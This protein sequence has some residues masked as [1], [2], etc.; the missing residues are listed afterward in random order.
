MKKQRI[1]KEAQIIASQYPFWMVSGDIA[2]LYG[3][4]L[5]TPEENYELEIKFGGDFPAS[6]PHLTYHDKIKD[7]LGDIQLK[8]LKDWDETSRTIDILNELKSKLQSAL[9][10]TSNLEQQNIDDA[11]QSTESSQTPSHDD[12]EYITPDLNAFPPESQ[13]NESN[14]LSSSGDELFYMPEDS[15]KESY[16]EIESEALASEN[17]VIS[18]DE[19]FASSDSPSVQIMT[20]LGLIQQ[21]Y[22]YDQKSESK[23]D[24]IVYMTITLTKTFLIHIDFSKYPQR[25]SIS[26]PDNV[27]RL[28]PDPYETLQ[29]LK[30]WKKKRPPHVID[31][32]HELEKKLYSI[33]PIEEQLQ[34]IAQE[35]QYTPQSD[36]LTKIQVSLLTYGFKQYKVELDLEP[37]P[38]P[39][40]INFLPDLRTLL[41]ISP[42]ELE[43]IKNWT[44]GE[45]DVI[46]VIR[47]IDWLVD[48]SSRINFELNLLKASYENIDYEPLT[49]SLTLNMK[50]KMRTENIVFEF[51]IELPRDYPMG[52]PEIT[53]LNEFEFEE[54]QAIKNDLDQSMANFFDEWTPYSYLV[55]LFNLIS[56]KIF[57][58]SVVSC[59]ICHD[60]DCPTCG[61]K[62]A[63]PDEETCFIECP[64]CERPYHKHCWDQTLKSFGKCGF[65]LK[66][67]PPGYMP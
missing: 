27:K 46:D 50:G 66:T 4:V 64:H 47:E 60:I 13:G 58:V 7:L 24:I 17:A 12:E 41:H 44:K 11:I 54:E 62:I 9:K 39:P 26:L 61:L 63:G 55:D 56:K 19:L 53:V 59:V 34:K 3:F 8:T 30:K 18:P 40:Q 28:I 52:M 21:Q 10:H 16:G 42:H 6:P 1:L 57:E 49:S 67:P 35:Y 48:K 45:S 43:S 20:E 22:A 51:K 32:L 37:H 38:E 33:K 65:C 25:P 5:K 2:H 23:A 36:T 29:T 15:N 14:S 31:I